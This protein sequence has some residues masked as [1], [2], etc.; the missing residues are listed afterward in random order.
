MPSDLPP[1]SLSL[2]GAPVLRR[3]GEPVTGRAAYRRRIAL[4]AVLA[5][6][7]GRPVGRQRLMGL[8][9]PE[10]SEEA[11]RHSLS[12]SLYL[13][14]RELGGVLAAR[15]SDVVLDPAGV[16][17]DLEAFERAL[18]EGRAED[19]V[20]AYGGPFLD[21]FYVDGA[22]EFERWAEGERDRLARAFARV[23]EALAEAAEDAGAPLR[24]AG[25]WRTLSGHDPY[26]SRI[27]LRLASALARG[28]EGAAALRHAEAH[29]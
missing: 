8:L 27:A 4:L 15:G 11:A 14:R 2:L 24:A 1:L 23:A 5:A 3:E 26:S 18:E 16:A 20:R 7:R 9:W 29:A 19:A 17:V 25:W 10:Q 13:L 21:G 28:G 12:E 22:P 6:A